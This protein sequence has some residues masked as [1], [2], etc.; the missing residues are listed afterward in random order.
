MTN[1][2]P[3]QT[4]GYIYHITTRAAAQQARES[5]EYRTESLAGQGF[6]HFSQL[7]QT[8]NVANAFYAGQSNLVILVVD[9]ARLKADLKFEGPIHP[10]SAQGA[11]SLP[12]VEVYPSSSG[13]DTLFPHLY[14]PL[15]FDAV[16]RQVDFP[17]GPQGSF[18]L[19]ALD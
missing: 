9:I 1:S 7:F 2:Y 14:G 10:A 11:A 12:A 5:G 4:G 8:L 17:L 13:A 16:V 15:N 18:E 6:I 19:P 3:T